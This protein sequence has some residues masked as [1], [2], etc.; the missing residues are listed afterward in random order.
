MYKMPKNP[1][2]VKASVF[3]ESCPARLLINRI[4]GK[5]SLL[6]IDL[7]GNKRLRNAQILRS[8]EGISQRVLTRTLRDLEEINIVARFDMQSVPPHVE[9]S[10]TVKGLSLRKK[11]CSLDRWI[12][13]NMLELVDNVKEIQ[14]Y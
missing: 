11:I 13:N 7:L 14:R 5:W 8:I 12:E 4:S 3:S 6:I 2:A 1:I 10:L 9:Y